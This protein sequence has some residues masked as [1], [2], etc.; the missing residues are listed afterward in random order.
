MP[1]LPSTSAAFVLKRKA[2]AKAEKAERVKEPP[3]VPVVKVRMAK[4]R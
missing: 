4:P 2:I 3:A 1:R